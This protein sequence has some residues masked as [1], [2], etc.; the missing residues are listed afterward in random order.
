[1]CL[2]RVQNVLCS[3]LQFNAVLLFLANSNAGC[4]AALRLFFVLHVINRCMLYM[5]VMLADGYV[6]L[7]FQLIK[8]TFACGKSVSLQRVYSFSSVFTST[9]AADACIQRKRNE[10]ESGRLLIFYHIPN[11]LFDLKNYTKADCAFHYWAEQDSKVF[12]QPSLVQPS[13][14]L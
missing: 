8:A 12:S 5:C 14:L 4:G 13:N 6:Y 2:C 10:L 7:S 1:M 3:W 11:Q 9:Y